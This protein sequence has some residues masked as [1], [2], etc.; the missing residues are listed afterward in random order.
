MAG[1][2]LKGDHFDNEVQRISSI[3]KLDA[4]GWREFYNRIKHVQKHSD[5]IK[6]YYE[7]AD[8]LTL[9]KRLLDIRTRLNGL[10]LSK[11]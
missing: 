9:A 6:K 1:T 7:G 8:T 11:L 10:L 5:D 3:S 4:T 2:Y